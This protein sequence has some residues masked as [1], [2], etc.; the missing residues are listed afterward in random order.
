[1]DILGL[2]AHDPEWYQ[3]LART[4]VV[5]ITALIFVKISGMRTFGT[6]SA[7]DVIVTITL[8]A[9]L[10]RCIMGHYPF[11][12]CLGAAFLLALMH[13]LVSYVSARSD[14]FHHLVSGRPQVLYKNKTFL[15]REMRKFCISDDDMHKAMHEN[16]IDDASKVSRIVLE[17]D[18]VLSVIREDNS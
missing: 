18:G 13:R 17:T 2:G 7:F 11:F 8:G 4:V 16:N 14:W 1:M 10:S 6:K 15:K 9:V 5:F 3:V 12:N